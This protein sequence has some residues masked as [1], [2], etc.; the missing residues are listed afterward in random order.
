[1]FEKDVGQK[2]IFEDPFKKLTGKDYSNANSL[3]QTGNGQILK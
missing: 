1:V 2:V 3:K